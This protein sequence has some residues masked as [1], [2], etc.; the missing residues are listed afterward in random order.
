MKLKYLP[1]LKICP[2]NS[3]TVH[4]A[5]APTEIIKSYCE[6]NK[7]E[8]STSLLTTSKYST[9]VNQKADESMG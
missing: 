3:A 4:D 5:K 7:I 2:Y 9:I 6:D 8:L 1:G